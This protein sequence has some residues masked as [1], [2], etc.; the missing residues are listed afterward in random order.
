MENSVL[1]RLFFWSQNAWPWMTAKR[2]SRSFV[3]IKLCWLWRQMRPRR[4]NGMPCLAYVYVNIP[5][6]TYC[7]IR[8]VSKFTVASCG[9]PCHST[10]FLIRITVERYLMVIWCGNRICG[11]LSIC[12]LFQIP[13]GYGLCQE[14]LELNDIWVSYDK[15]KRVK[16]FSETQCTSC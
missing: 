2:D 3:Q 9:S 15:F 1:R 16:F 13:W 8:Y 11:G 4:Q 10:A 12:N 6:S 5:L 14:L 7:K